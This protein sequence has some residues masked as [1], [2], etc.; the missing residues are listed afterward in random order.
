MQRN[1]PFG[2]ASLN[3]MYCE[4]TLSSFFTIVESDGC[5]FFLAAG[6]SF[7]LRFM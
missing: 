6:F 2:I 4:K 7:A 3:L 1:T 5:R